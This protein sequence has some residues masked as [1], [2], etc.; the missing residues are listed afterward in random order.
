MTKWKKGLVAKCRKVK[1]GY[2][3]LRNDIDYL[4]LV[5]IRYEKVMINNAFAK[6]SRSSSIS[7]EVFPANGMKRSKRKRKERCDLNKDST[8]N[9]GKE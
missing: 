5:A 8:K 2:G 6:E 1:Q 7:N 9:L 3:K 4:D